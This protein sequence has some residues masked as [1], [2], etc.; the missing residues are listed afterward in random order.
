VT[1]SED[2]PK[3]RIEGHAIVS[4]DDRIATPDGETPAALSNEADWLRFQAALDESA[5]VVLGRLSHE[6]NPNTARRNRLIVSTAAGGVERRSDGWWWNPAE[7][8]LPVALKSA[9]PNGG[10]VAVPGG[11]LIFDLI[12]KIGFDA[13]HLARATQVRIPD[14]VPLFSAI[15]PR[16]NAEDVLTG[17]GLVAGPVETLDETAGVTLVIWRR[18]A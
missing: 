12:L 16:R 14:G 13:F 15:G 9:A 17:A 2:L 3:Y 5:V 1:A 11:R 6:A 18:A 10:I 7:A 4:V 8:P